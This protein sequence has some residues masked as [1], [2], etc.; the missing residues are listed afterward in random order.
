MDVVVSSKP[1]AVRNA[2]AEDQ[3]LTPKTKA[4]K[5]SSPMFPGCFVTFKDIF[6]SANAV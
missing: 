1:R 4:L 2:G 6:V 5:I 3:V